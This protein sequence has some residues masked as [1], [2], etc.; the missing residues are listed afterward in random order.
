MPWQDAGAPRSQSSTGER[1]GHMQGAQFFALRRDEPCCI[2]VRYRCLSAHSANP[3][4]LVQSAAAAAVTAVAAMQA[5]VQQA[6]KEAQQ[7]A[8]TLTDAA[9]KA[10]HAQAAAQAAHA[11]FEGRGS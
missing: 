10:E 8:H 4:M 9:A 11:A 2:V 7:T 1:I 6:A 3:R 5:A